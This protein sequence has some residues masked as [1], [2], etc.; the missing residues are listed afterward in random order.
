MRCAPAGPHAD[1]R[2][3]D[4][5]ADVG[6]RRHARRRV[7]TRQRRRAAA[8]GRSER[9]RGRVRVPRIAGRV[10]RPARRSLPTAARWW[11]TC[12]RSRSTGFD[13]RGCAARVTYASRAAL[14]SGPPACPRTRAT[15]PASFPP[16][17]IRYHRP[18]RRP[19]RHRLT[20]RTSMNIRF[21]ETFVWLAKLENFRLTAE[22]CTPHRPPYRAA[23]RR[24][25][26]HSTCA[27]STATR[28]RPRSRPPGADARVRG[29]DRAARRRNAPRHRCGE[30]CGPDPDRRDRIDRAQ[31]V[32][33]A[34]GATARALSAPRRRDH[35][36]HDTAPDPPAQHRR[37]RP[38]PADRPG[39]GPDFTN[40]PLCEFPVRW[41]A[42]P[43]LAAR[44]STSRASRHSRSSASRHSPHATIE[45]LFAAVERPASINCITSVAAMIRLVA[46]GFGGR[47]AARDHR[48]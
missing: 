23:S 41:A 35:E 32:P 10:V 7:C 22:N 8:R 28:V 36:R 43:R 21:L 46:D 11:W 39:A 26:R 16:P 40:L 34:D 42:S 24:S 29:A 37:R 25:R 9:D 19:A 47:A 12:R 13:A 27:C 38:D 15:S 45:R 6:A 44:R 3:G 1:G 2:R 48:A 5:T 14:R 31:L 18:I 33:H 17:K 30:R 4:G 20:V